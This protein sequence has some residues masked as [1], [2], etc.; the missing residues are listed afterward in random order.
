MKNLITVCVELAVEEAIDL[1][2]QTTEGMNVHNLQVCSWSA[3][4][5]WQA[6]GWSPILYWKRS[7]SC[8]SVMVE[9]IVE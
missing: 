3:D 9:Q 2:R 7:L 4:T 5:T 1:V 6:K 8:C